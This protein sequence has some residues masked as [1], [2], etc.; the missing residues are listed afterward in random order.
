MSRVAERQRW[1]GP[2]DLYLESDQQISAISSRNNEG[3]T[4][5][6]LQPGRN[7]RPSFQTTSERKGSRVRSSTRDKDCRYRIGRGWAKEGRATR[8]GRVTEFW[9]AF[10]VLTAAHEA[11]E[12]I[13]IRQ[14]DAVSHFGLVVQAVDLATVFRNT[15]ER[16]M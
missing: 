6:Q 12:T 2:L 5:S 8:I 14:H 7:I 1:S 3:R 15:G 4:Q 9:L 13:D 11:H 10:F 16:R